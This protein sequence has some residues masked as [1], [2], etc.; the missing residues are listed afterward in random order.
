MSF[1]GKTDAVKAIMKVRTIGVER[2]KATNHSDTAT[3]EVVRAREFMFEELTFNFKCR[4]TLRCDYHVTSSW[5]SRVCGRGEE[6]GALSEWSSL[7]QL[8]T[9][10]MPRN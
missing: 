10:E 2:S 1:G 3:L 5:T 8:K 7:P 6:C 9:L 4:M